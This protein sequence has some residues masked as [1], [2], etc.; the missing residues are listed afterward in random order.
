MPLL[1]DAVGHSDSAAA[2]D[3]DLKHVASQAAGMLPSDLMAISADAASSAALQSACVDC[4]AILSGQQHGHEKQ[5]SEAPLGPLKLTAEHYES[6]L[7]NLRQRTAVAIGAP[8]V[9]LHACPVA[10]PHAHPLIVFKP[11]LSAHMHCSDIAVHGIPRAFHPECK[12]VGARR[13]GLSL[14]VARRS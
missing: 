14:H 1:Q 8:Q 11:G 5:P 3:V 10:K 12:Y 4:T 7:Q 2:V 9:G 6:G 13:A